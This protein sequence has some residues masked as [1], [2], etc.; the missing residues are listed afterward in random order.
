MSNRRV[1]GANYVD[2]TGNL[3]EKPGFARKIKGNPKNFYAFVFFGGE[4]EKREK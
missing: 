4:I 3:C 1:F 2:F